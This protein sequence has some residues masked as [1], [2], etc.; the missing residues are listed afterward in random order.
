MTENKYRTSLDGLVIEN[1][2]ESFF[3]YC[4]ERENIR[5]KRESGEA[6][7]WSEDQIFQKVR[8]THIL[9]IISV[10]TFHFTYLKIISFMIKKL[11]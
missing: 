4:I 9:L 1:P 3:N 2:V 8:V 5:I 6:F 11:L 7:P 10:K